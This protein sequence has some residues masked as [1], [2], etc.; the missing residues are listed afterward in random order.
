MAAATDSTV[1]AERAALATIKVEDFEMLNTL[2]AFLLLTDSPVVPL[3]GAAPAIA[4]HLIPP[5]PQC[6]RSALLTICADASIPA[7]RNWYVW[8]GQALH[9]ERE[10]L[11]NENPAEIRGEPSS[12]GL[13]SH[14]A[15]SCPYAL[16]T[17]LRWGCVWAWSLW[18]WSMSEI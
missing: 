2:G 6:L 17:R 14:T 11:R 1:T 5:L 7:Y 10:S 16:L 8:A 15:L 3:L 12:L 4:L 9:T 13:G 18:S